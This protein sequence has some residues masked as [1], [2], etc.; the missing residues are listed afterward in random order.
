MGSVVGEGR[1]TCASS[2]EWLS[3]VAW[4]EL[5]LMGILHHARFAIHVERAFSALLEQLGHGYDPDPSVHPDRRHA[6]VSFTAAYESPV[7]APGPV[8]VRLTVRRLGDSSLT[9][10]W[11]VHSACGTVQHAQGE[12]VVVHVGRDNRSAPWS[13]AFRASLAPAEAVEA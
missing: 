5:D 9:M 13:R 8:L 12:R 7:T 1:V 11:S 2:F 10:G 6:V 3:P 4:D